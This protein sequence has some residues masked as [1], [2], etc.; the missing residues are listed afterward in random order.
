[1]R[2]PSACKDGK[3]IDCRVNAEIVACAQV[4]RHASNSG[5]RDAITQKLRALLHFTSYNSIMD[6]GM[7]DTVE[8]LLKESITLRAILTKEAK[9]RKI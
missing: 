3:C 2:T 9:R 1:M 4:L 5:A 6:C 8:E 7:T